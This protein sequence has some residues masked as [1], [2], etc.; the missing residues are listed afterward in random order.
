MM[1]PA[2]FHIPT[3]FVPP[4]EIFKS[5]NNTEGCDTSRNCQS[6]GKMATNTVA[7]S[8]GGEIVTAVVI[9]NYH[10]NYLLPL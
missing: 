3:T 2:P 9:G 6:A 7:G 4:T 1:N 8:D 5:L 10:L